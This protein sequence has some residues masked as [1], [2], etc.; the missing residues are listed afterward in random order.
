MSLLS[1]C[2]STGTLSGV[3]APW[4]LFQDRCRDALLRFKT[5]RALLIPEVAKK[6]RIA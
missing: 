2:E 4:P 6:Q 3:T 1:T 5:S